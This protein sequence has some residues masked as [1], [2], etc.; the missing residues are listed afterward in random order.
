MMKIHGT[1]PPYSETEP[2]LLKALPATWFTTQPRTIIPLTLP[3]TSVMVRPFTA[4]TGQTMDPKPSL[5]RSTLL[6][7]LLRSTFRFFPTNTKISSRTRKRPFV[8]FGLGQGQLDTNP[9]KADP[10]EA[11]QTGAVEMAADSTETDPMKANQTEADWMETWEAKQARCRSGPGLEMERKTGSRNEAQNSALKRAA[12][13]G[14]SLC[15]LSRSK[16]W[17]T[18]KINPARRLTDDS[19]RAAG[20]RRN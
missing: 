12:K 11:D 15:R 9:M 4:T 2:T 20:S 19:G 7:V 3:S 17:C 10:R 6:P 8:R 1:I 5:L 18:I 16:G 14:G 13:N